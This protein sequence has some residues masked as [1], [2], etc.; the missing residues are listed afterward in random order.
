MNIQG[1]LS[2][3]Y[4]SLNNRKY[5][6]NFKTQKLRVFQPGYSHSLAY[7]NSI[8]YNQNCEH[9]DIH[10]RSASYV[11]TVSQTRLLDDIDSNNL[12][13][14]CGIHKQHTLATIV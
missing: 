2:S 13:I 9:L 5:F 10:V 12:A 6:A 8:S 4:E 14:Q 1:N 3:T 11:K 7:S